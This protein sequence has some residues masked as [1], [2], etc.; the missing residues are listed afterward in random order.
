MEREAYA[1]YVLATEYW[2][3]AF[4][5]LPCI[6]Y[7]DHKNLIWKITINYL[8]FVSRKTIT[9]VKLYM[10][11]NENTYVWHVVEITPVTN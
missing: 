4:K 3:K 1:I 11:K 7:S 5:G 6:I 9:F 10:S 2:Q 8:H